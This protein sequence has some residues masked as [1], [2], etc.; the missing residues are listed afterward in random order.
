MDWIS[1]RMEPALEREKNK[2]IYTVIVC[3]D[4][5]VKIGKGIIGKFLISLLS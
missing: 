2:L 4:E 1:C 3:P 5:V